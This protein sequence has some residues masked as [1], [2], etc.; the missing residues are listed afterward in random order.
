MMYI[1]VYLLV[2]RVKISF[3]PFFVPQILSQGIHAMIYDNTET[4]CISIYV[5]MKHFIST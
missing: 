3:F 4:L 1:F 5:R 2:I